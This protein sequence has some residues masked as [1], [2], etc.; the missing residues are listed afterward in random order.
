MNQILSLVST[1]SELGDVH[2]FISA[3]NN[4]SN[5]FQVSIQ[6]HRT[7]TQSRTLWRCLKGGEGQVGVVTMLERSSAENCNVHHQDVSSLLFP[8][9]KHACT[10]ICGCNHVCLCVYILL[11]VSLRA[12]VPLLS[13]LC[14]CSVFLCTYL[15]QQFTFCG[16]MWGNYGVI[17][18]KI[19]ITFFE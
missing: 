14:A 4:A 1:H 11:C 13:V 10:Y 12:V 19:R 18:E 15:Q 7:S 6:T 16:Y 17:Y 9:I 3:I 8:Q 2:N 5:L